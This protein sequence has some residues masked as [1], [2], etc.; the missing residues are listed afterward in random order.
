[1]KNIHTFQERGTHSVLYCQVNPFTG[2]WLSRKFC[3]QFSF[4]MSSIYS[5]IFL[6]C[7][8][9]QED[10][11]Q[12]PDSLE[13]LYPQAHS[14][15]WRHICSHT[16]VRHELYY[17]INL[18]GSLLNGWGAI[19]PQYTETDWGIIYVLFVTLFLFMFCFFRWTWS[20]PDWIWACGH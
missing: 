15:S 18:A 5:Y 12:N 13:Y 19:I 16:A 14:Q 10:I 1:M 17:S 11:M 20:D 6:F 7:P 8:L 9:Y 2:Y 4:N 3:S